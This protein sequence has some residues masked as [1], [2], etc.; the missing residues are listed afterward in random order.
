MVLLM[1]AFLLIGLV[2][3]LAAYCLRDPKIQNYSSLILRQV[4]VTLILFNCFNISFSAGIH[5]KYAKTT[6]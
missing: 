1:L 4:L 3:F 5:W 2:L 6:D